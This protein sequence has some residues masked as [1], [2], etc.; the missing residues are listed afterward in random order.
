M[1]NNKYDIKFL[2]NPQKYNIAGNIIEGTPVGQDITGKILLNPYIDIKCRGLWL[3]IGYREHG[4]GTPYENRLFNEKFY[5]GPL[6]KYSQIEKPFKFTIPSSGPIT[7][8]GHYVKID[9]FVRLRIDI[10]IWPD[11]REQLNFK[12][13]PAI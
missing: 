1:P 13:I 10:P 8:N 11:P 9:W 2:I 6:T 12:V 4:N 3:E 5:D 7:Y